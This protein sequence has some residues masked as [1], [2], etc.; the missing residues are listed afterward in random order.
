MIPFYDLRLV[1]R[2]VANSIDEALSAVLDRGWFIRGE[3]GARFEREFAAYCGAKHAIGVGNGLDALSLILEAYLTRGDMS[4]GDEVIV[5]ANTFVASVLAVA[6][7]GLRPILLE[8]DERT[9]N[10]DPTA[11]AAALTPRTRAILW[12]HLYGQC[13]AADDLRELARSR[14][15]KLIEDAAQA[16]GAVCGG[17]RAGSL[18]DAAGFSFYPTK[19]L[20]ALGDGGAV[21][22]DDDELAETVRLLGNYGSRVK[23]ENLL[24]GRNSRLDELQ[25]AVLSVKLPRLDADNTRRKAVAERYRTEIRNPAVRLPEC[26]DPAAHV[27]HLF[28]VRV[29]DRDRFRRHLSDCGVETGVHYPIPPHRQAAFPEWHGLSL[30]ITERIHREVASLPMSPVLTDHDVSCVIS[31]VNS[32][33]AL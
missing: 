4:H 28:V 23:Y 10:L 29:A 7:V 31:Q 1:N 19:N 3:S 17:R 24:P 12:V 15:L 16:H 18:G 25:A 2:S 27:W 33:P 11:V 5:P 22:T 26:P 30:P 14:G 32:Y 9:F 8:P 13:S 6:A 21:T 20:G